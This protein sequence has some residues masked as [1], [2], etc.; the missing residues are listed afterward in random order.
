[1][2]S[3]TSRGV[4]NKIGDEFN[5]HCQWMTEARAESLADGNYERYIDMKEEY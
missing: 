4:W 5:R 1:M 2:T 3:R